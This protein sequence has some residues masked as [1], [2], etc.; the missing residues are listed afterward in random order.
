LKGISAL[1]LLSLLLALVMLSGCIGPKDTDKDG[2][3]DEDDHFPED[4]NEWLD[5][6]NDGVGDNSD[7]FPNDSQE[8]ADS[9][10]DGYGD[11][12]DD[13]PN[14]PDEW[15]DTDGDGHGDNSDEFP[16]DWEEWEDSDG[17]G[18]GDNSDDYPDDPAYHTTCPRCNGTGKV[19]ESEDFIYSASAKLVDQGY[20]SPEWHVMVT[21]VNRDREAGMFRVEASVVQ[22]GEVVWSGEEKRSIRPQDQHTFDFRASGFTQS[23]SQGNLRYEV[24]PPFRIIGPEMVCPRCNG[25]GKI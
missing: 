2:H 19:P 6:D 16:E 15:Y 14:D 7:A 17:D 23:V 18:H 24:H 10:G 11:N 20:T 5:S 1:G 25:T 8:T 4:P 13:F 9:D 22:G 12:S 3:P 21:V